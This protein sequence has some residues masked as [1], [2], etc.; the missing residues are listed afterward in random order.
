MGWVPVARP[1]MEPP[2]PFPPAPPLR[3]PGDSDEEVIAR[4]LPPPLRPIFLSIDR[5]IASRVPRFRRGTYSPGP[6]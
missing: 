4:D 5:E 3:K 1:R 2:F 6:G